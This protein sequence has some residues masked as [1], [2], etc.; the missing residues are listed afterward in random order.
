MYRCCLFG[1]SFIS[2][3]LICM[4]DP[5]FTGF[6]PFILHLLMTYATCTYTRLS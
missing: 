3:L 4:F 5:F 2:S 1:I 6:I